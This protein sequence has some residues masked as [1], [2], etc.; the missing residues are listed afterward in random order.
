MFGRSSS[1]NDV[2]ML[3]KEGLLDFF[4]QR[5]QSPGRPLGRSASARRHR[6]TMMSTADRE[7]Q[8]YLELF[9]GSAGGPAG[10]ADCSKFNSLPRSGRAGQRR[11]TPWIL[12][13]D[14][15]REL[16]GFDRL[17]TSPR[18]E[19]EPISPLARF[20]SPGLHDDPRSD[21]NNVALSCVSE[22]SSHPSVFQK[23]ACL[24][25]GTVT[26]HIN[27]SVEKHTLVRGP[28][29]FEL[30]NNS[31]SNNL[32]FVLQFDAPAADLEGREA[33]KTAHLKLALVSPDRDK[34]DEDVSTFSSTTCDTP[35][36][37]D[38]SASNKRPAFSVP[39]CTETDCSVALDYS[40]VESS[41][42][43][44]E[45]LF[46][47][48]EEQQQEPS[49][50]PL[51]EPPADRPTT[52]N[53]LV[54][55]TTPSGGAEDWD[56][57]SCDTAEGRH[58]EEKGGK[59]AAPTRSSVYKATKSSAGRAVRTLTGSESQGL[60]KVVPI[61]KQAR[62]GA[63]RRA[64][65]REGRESEAS[66]RGL[67]D[68]STPAAR[69]RGERLVRPPRHSSLPPDEA[70]V[71][72][73]SNGAGGL[74]GGGASSRWARDSTAR[75]PGAK[76]AR[77][78]AKAPPEEK[79][80]R[81]TMRA[82]AVLQPPAAA[83][84]ASSDNSATSARTACDVPSF[85]R[86]TVASTSRTKKE[87]VP[88]LLLQPPSSVPGTPSR[89]PSLRGRQTSLRQSRPSTSVPSDEERPLG[90]GLRRVQS[91]KATSRSARRAD[92]PPPPTAQV[93]EDGRK[94]GSSVANGRNAKP[95][96]K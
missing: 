91:V 51:E 46:G 10:P 56:T 50:R 62:T 27:V 54:A 74:G 57:E 22:S 36:P 83:T 67:R 64:E 93:H 41:P 11:T 9:G 86:N 12:A 59:R 88:P 6:H 37:L 58:G 95:S 21:N 19:T 38:T 49:L 55:S 42:P 78:T 23:S 25:V 33:S 29:A 96:W 68:Q 35:L 79:M 40:E 43:A 66:R 94:P 7:L 1:E 65:G 8:G 84:A 4:Q 80:C 75:K 72:G 76:P 85:A 89:S 47:V 60:R 39:D 18:A 16:A 73:R 52:A 87:V 48:A 13:Q 61:G 28:R 15:N 17:V 45:P 77:N 53:K 24:P 2:E 14:D 30:N 31:G 81:S 82:L 70:K 20:S 69:G 92:T 63:M 3:T 71:A 5:S 44:Q 32:N 26:G 34:E 90:A